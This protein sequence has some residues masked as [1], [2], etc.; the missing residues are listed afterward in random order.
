MQIVR[1]GKLSRLQHL[2][3]IRGKTVAIVSS[4]QYLLTSLN[5]L[6]LENFCD[7]VFHRERF[8]LYGT[9]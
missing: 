6:M 1:D 3:E 5:E 8:A 7:K 4:M 2:I 9:V